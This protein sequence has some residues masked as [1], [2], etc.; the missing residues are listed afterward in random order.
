MRVILKNEVAHLG[1]AGEIVNVRDGYG[2]NYLIP[3]GLAIPASKGSV[4]QA[5][6]EQ[7]VASAIQRKQLTGARALAEQLSNMAVTI[8]REAAD[9]SKLFG[10]VTNRDIAEA[11]AA[12]GLELD[13]RKIELEEHI[14][15][16][17]LYNVPVRLHREVTASVRVYVIAG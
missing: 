12:E 14:R 4:K 2:R 16:V 7:R 1:D 5:E 13:R 17:G 9:D 3:R 8:R 10:S 11:L 6:H 15:T